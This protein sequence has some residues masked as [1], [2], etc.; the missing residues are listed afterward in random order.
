M[1][2]DRANALMD[3][4]LEHCRDAGVA[5]I[6]HTESADAAV[7]ADLAAHARAAG[8]PLGKAVKHYAPPIVGPENAGLLPSVIASADSA[9]QAAREGTRFLLETD[10]IDEPE[11]PGAVLGPKTVPR[12]ML[13]LVG[14]GV[15]TEEQAWEVA[16]NAE[17]AYGISLALP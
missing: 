17:R 14:R 7:F 15:L 10:Y 2:W 8:L 3:R 16:R 9:E 11:R 12:R 4:A 5:A 6:L 1:V 13:E